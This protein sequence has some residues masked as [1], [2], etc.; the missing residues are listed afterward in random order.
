MDD[1]NKKYVM[2]S[3]LTSDETKMK[4]LIQ[5]KKDMIANKN[6]LPEKLDQD[7]ANGWISAVKKEL[8]ENEGKALERPKEGLNNTDNHFAQMIDE[9]ID[10]MLRE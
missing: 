6:N 5:E 9:K 8:T 10:F 4:E 3:N 1:N 7:R 2:D